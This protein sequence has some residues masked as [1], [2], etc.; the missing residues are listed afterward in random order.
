M[1]RNSKYIT[2]NNKSIPEKYKDSILAALAFFPELKD[3]RIIFELTD[4]NSML[5]STKPVLTS[6]F[7]PPSKRK[8]KVSLLE[9]AEEPHYSALYKN[10]TEEKRVA[11]IAHE[12]THVIQF[13]FCT[14]PKLLMKLIGYSFPAFKKKLERDADLGAITHGQG[15]GCIIMLFIC[16]A[17][18]VTWRS[19]RK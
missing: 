14:A 9:K 17:F 3:A 10:L 12:L 18:P 4:K 8:Y 16:A 6:I 15:M 13:H 11:V 19:V 2:I 5:Y 1:E 7:L